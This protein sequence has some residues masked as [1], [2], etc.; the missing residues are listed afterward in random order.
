MQQN[1]NLKTL[2][3]FFF[4]ISMTVVAIG[5]HDGVECGSDVHHQ[6][7][8]AN[9]PAYK[10][11]MAAN[12]AEYQRFLQSP[13]MQRLRST[14]CSG[15][16]LRVPIVFHVMHPGSIA[17]TPGFSPDAGII[18]AVQGLNDRWQ[19]IVGDGVDIGFEFCLAKRDPDGNPTTGIVRIDASGV[20]DYV[21]EGV[22]FGSGPPGIDAAL[23]KVLSV[24]PRPIITMSGWCMISPDL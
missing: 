7:M 9:D 24:W 3:A 1:L 16:P 14:G 18:A 17:S 21:A 2:L 12:E 19:G 20:P 13:A 4:L 6:W 23:I 11:A 5:Q 8:M 15:E 10:A 22:A